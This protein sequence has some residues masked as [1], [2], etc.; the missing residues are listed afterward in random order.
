MT[1]AA[2]WDLFCETGDLMHYLFYREALALEQ[3]EDK[4]A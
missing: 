1:S 2:F 3:T 4:T